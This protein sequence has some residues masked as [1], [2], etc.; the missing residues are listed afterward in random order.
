MRRQIDLAILVVWDLE[1]PTGTLD[2]SSSLLAEA[3]TL[4]RARHCPGQIEALRLVGRTA[5]TQS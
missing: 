1:L 5:S 2:T 3:R 4:H